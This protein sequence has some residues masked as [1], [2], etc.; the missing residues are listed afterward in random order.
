MLN[1]LE[2][3]ERNQ[4]KEEKECALFEAMNKVK[5]AANS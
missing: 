1:R 3:E 5:L 4:K 2:F